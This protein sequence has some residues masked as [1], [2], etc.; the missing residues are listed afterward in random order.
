MGFWEL[1]TN[2]RRNLTVAV[3]P[4]RTFADVI[5]PDTTIRALEYAL[6]Q[7]EKR[8]L[9]FNHWGL[10]ERHADGLGLAFAFA[11]PPGTGKTIC[12]EAL[13]HA[14]GKKLLVVRYSEL[15]SMWVGETGKNVAALFRTAAEQD[16]VLLFDEADAIASRRFE[17]ISYGY[18]REANAVI[19]V[20]LSELE[21][22]PGVTIFATNLAANFDP[23]FERRIRTHILFELPGAPE[24]ELIWRAQLH[25]DKTP[26]ADDVDFRALAEEFAVSGG[27]IK[28]AVLKAAQI[29][30]LEPGQDASKRIHQRHFQE[31]MRE[32]LRAKKVMEQSLFDSGRTGGPTPGLSMI[33]R[34]WAAEQ[35]DT[36]RRVDDL[37]ERIES[38]QRAVAL[39]VEE[40][41]RTLRRLQAAG[42]I[43]LVTFLLAVL[44]FLTIR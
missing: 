10:G 21:R 8:D 17:S 2:A 41:R 38:A 28:N 20:L 6:T 3:K 11:G 4:T 18:E 32:V 7:I 15:E 42:I 31:G 40:L 16:A 5:L 30:S 26:L 33:A 24:R 22:F 44:A 19:N 43:V 12:A 9:I 13:A 39:S 36:Q 23:A 34:E 25:A 29:A 27:D 14:L 1:L 35:K 37:S